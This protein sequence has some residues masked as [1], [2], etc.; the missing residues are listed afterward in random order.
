LSF[1]LDRSLRRF[2]PQR[3]RS[4]LRRRAD[5]ELP[6]ISEQPAGGLDL[7]LDTCV[8]I[9]ILQG[10]AP[11]P[12]KRLLGIRVC[13]HS[14]VAL[15]ELTHLFGRLDPG[16]NRTRAVLAE[17]AGTISQIPQHRLRA[18][19]LGALGEAG[20]LAG[21]VARLTNL[22][23]RRR[24]PLFNDAA[25]YLQAVEN[26]QVVLTRNLRDFD[27]FDQLLPCGRV[28][29]YRRTPASLRQS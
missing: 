18:P 19:S 27:C 2:K 5:E 24:Q 7:L 8:Y 13:H 25:L 10:R 12:V 28:L 29:L 20:I 11:E 14:G 4:G 1:D 17:L 6:Q 3:R 16:D 23:V 22:E 26:G 9:D 21:L 15:A